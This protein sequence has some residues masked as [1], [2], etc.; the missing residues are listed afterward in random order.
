M[1]QP[2]LRSTDFT[3]FV[4]PH[5]AAMRSYARRLVD[6]ADYEDVVQ[7]VLLKLY[8][9]GDRLAEVRE[10]RPWLMS[11]VYHRAID[12]IRRRVRERQVEIGGLM[13]AGPDGE[14]AQEWECN[15]PGP[16]E[17]MHQ[18]QTQDLVSDA[19]GD[20]PEHQREVVRLHDL[21]GLTLAEIAEIH[22]I[23]VN[24]LKST[25]SRGRQG[26]RSRLE[27]TSHGALA[28][29]GMAARAGGRGGRRRGRPARP[30]SGPQPEG[31]PT[32]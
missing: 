19:L 14:P 10:V 18:A 4:Q 1:N 2:T 25:L 12:L 17:L 28:L 13:N 9:L 6:D 32:P 5:L 27:I 23:S 15:E 3:A 22:R 20:L 31:S 30:L 7:D 21:E 26:L 8:Q 16:D 11:A 29:R 24:T